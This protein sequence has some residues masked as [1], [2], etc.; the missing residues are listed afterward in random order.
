M[1]LLPAVLAAL[2][3]VRAAS[4]TA[5]LEDELGLTPLA[6]VALLEGSLKAGPVG[7]NEG[8]KLRGSRICFSHFSF[9]IS[10]GGG[11]PLSDCADATLRAAKHINVATST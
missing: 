6:D 11:L 4:E 8:S 10:T 9:R 7:T 3:G 1:L 5:P 2:N